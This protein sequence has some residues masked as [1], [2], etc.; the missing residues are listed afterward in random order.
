MK[1]RKEAY[2]EQGVCHECL[3]CNAGFAN[4]YEH[5]CTTKPA[6]WK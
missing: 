3:M 4:E 2:H 5:L 1:F 6:T